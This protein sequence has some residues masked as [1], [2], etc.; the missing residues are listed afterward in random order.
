MAQL[1]S[2]NHSSRA[3]TRLFV[4]FVS[5]FLLPCVVV[6]AGFLLTGYAFAQNPIGDD[7]GLSQ[8]RW[9]EADQVVGQVS[10]VSGKIVRVGRSGNGRVN[11]LNFDKQRRDV[12]TVV[13]FNVDEKNFP[14]PLRE[15]YDQKLVSVRG[16]VTL[17][18]EVPQIRVRSMDQIRVVDRLPPTQIR[19][20]A[21]RRVGSQIRVA[22]F[23]IRN[24]F[25]GIDDPYHL[26]ETTKAKP[27]TELDRLAATIK[28]IDADVL[29]LQEVETRGY[30]E[31]FNDVFLNELGYEVVH[32]SGNDRRGSGLAMLTRVPVGQ[33][34]S[35]R[36]RRFPGK[37][38]V[39]TRFSRDLLCVEL[40]PRSGKD[41]EV[42]ITHLKSK[43][44]GPAVTEPKRVA[45]AREIQRL[46]QERLDEKP[47]ARIL[48]CGDFNDTIESNPIRE[49]IG[50][51]ASRLTS[52]WQTVPSGSVT[53]NLSPYQAMID[54]I[55]CSPSAARD[56]ADGTYRIESLSLSQSGSDHNPVIAD[57]R[58]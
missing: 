45:E 28:K 43:R 48:I 17:Y 41:F 12:F 57:F 35:N 31:R 14:K 40:E 9:N 24:L 47:D 39:M 34:T 53:Y 8:V 42:W 11:F 3:L 29:A 49:L 30:L 37:D 5:R 18:K 26:D 20:R 56:Y 10:I 50:E 1:P 25:D 55:F 32:F 23:N 19:K 38:G 51:G 13:I 6:A 52:Y 27:R 2:H 44:E 15:M 54:F 21:T 36:H 58:F 46:Y 7:E 33:V 4:G 16:E 22:T